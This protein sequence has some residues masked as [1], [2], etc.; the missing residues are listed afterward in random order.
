[1]ATHI[2]QFVI[3]QFYKQNMWQR[4]KASDENSDWLLVIVLWCCLQDI[5]F[6]KKAELLAWRGPTKIEQQQ[7]I[8]E[9][10]CYS[11]WNSQNTNS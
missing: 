3:L 6:L 9:I 4:H 11:A 8:P 2:T 10:F 1:M 7:S 5:L